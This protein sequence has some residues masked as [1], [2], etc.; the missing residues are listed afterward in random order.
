MS[1]SLALIGLCIV[2]PVS[3]LA[4]IYGRFVRNITRELQDRLADTT[5]V[6]IVKELYS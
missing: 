4:V 5:E 1:P 6:C 2:P 3:I